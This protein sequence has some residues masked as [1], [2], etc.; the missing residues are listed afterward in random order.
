MDVVRQSNKMGFLDFLSKKDASSIPHS[1]ARRMVYLHRLEELKAK[2][3]A[4]KDQRT[5]EGMVHSFLEEFFSTFFGV[6]AKSNM[7]AIKQIESSVS[8]PKLSNR[9]TALYKRWTQYRKMG[10]QLGEAE[11]SEFISSCEEM[12]QQL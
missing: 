6:S 12:L 11:I 5:K 7:D 10:M 4:E 8:D 9:A 1:D 3:A 2:L